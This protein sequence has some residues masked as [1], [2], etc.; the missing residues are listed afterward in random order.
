MN[1]VQMKNGKYLNNFL[2]N[3]AAHFG[4]KLMFNKTECDEP[5]ILIAHRSECDNKLKRMKI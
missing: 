4:Y 1:S 5:V 2:F 3:G